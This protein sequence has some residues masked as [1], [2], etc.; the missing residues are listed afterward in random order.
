MTSPT[1]PSL[2]I[3]HTP[4]P[5]FRSAPIAYVMSTVE[6]T[7]VVELFEL[8]EGLDI[9]T[10]VDVRRE[11]RL[12]RDGAQLSEVILGAGYG[13]LP[14]GVPAEGDRAIELLAELAPVLT[15][16]DSADR[17]AVHDSLAR[18]RRLEV[19]ADGSLHT[20]SERL[21]LPEFDT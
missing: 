11:P 19:D 5:A 7:N 12:L 3:S 17:P 15:L 2:D 16:C 13:Y 18:I 9:Q 10:L 4:I 20:I 1:P 6:Q 21:Q 8:M 14:R